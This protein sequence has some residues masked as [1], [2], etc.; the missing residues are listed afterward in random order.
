MVNW[1]AFLLNIFAILLNRFACSLEWLNSF[2][3]IAR[4]F[5]L[6]AIMLANNANMLNPFDKMLDI[7][8]KM[9][10]ANFSTKWA[11][12]IYGISSFLISSHTHSIWL[13]WKSFSK[14]INPISKFSSTDFASVIVS[15]CAKTKSCASTTTRNG[16]FSPAW[17]TN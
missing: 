11:N 16:S 13:I 5:N 4:T 15:I 3:I 8:S 7:F 14:Y 6:F 10:F 1:F 17:A 9:L 2:N 12:A